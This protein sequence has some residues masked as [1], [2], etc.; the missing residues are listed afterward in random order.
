MKLFTYRDFQVV[1]SEEA[2]ILKP[3]KKLW[4]RDKSLKKEKALQELGFIY[5]YCDP[6]SDYMFIVDEDLR[7]EKI[8]EQEG[9]SKTWNPDRFVKEAITLYKYL[10]ET[11]ASLL[12]ADTRVAVDKLREMLINLDLN[13]KD[14]RN[15]PI[16]TLNVITSTIKQIPSLTKDLIDAEKALMRDLDDI[17]RMRGQGIKKLFEDGL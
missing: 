13:E 15:K 5:F 9:L 12:L 10:T 3:F 7:I 4:D 11:T 14:D 16:Y 17:S 8:K 2:L 6:R 1:I